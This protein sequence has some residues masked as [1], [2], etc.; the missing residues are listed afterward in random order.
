MIKTFI[1]VIS[2]WGYNGS[3]WVYT[4]NQIVFQESMPKEQ[5]ETIVNNW[6]KFEMNKYFRF[7]IECIENIRKET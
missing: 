2:L 5:C 4:G 1:L 3:S 7:S 6:K